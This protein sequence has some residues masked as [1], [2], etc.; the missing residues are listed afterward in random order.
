VRRLCAVSPAALSP[1]AFDGCGADVAALSA[2]GA[3]R[4]VAEPEVAG[5]LAVV[6]VVQVWSHRAERVT[7]AGAW[8]GG[9]VTLR[10]FAPGFLMCAAVAR[11]GGVARSDGAE[12][13]GRHSQAARSCGLGH[14]AITSRS[15]VRRAEAETELHDCLPKG[16]PGSGEVEPGGDEATPSTRFRGCVACHSSDHAQW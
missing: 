10:C 6:V 8:V 2:G 9:V 5:A 15:I 4:A 1:V 11:C 14:C 12:T 3:W 13:M 16:V 7:A